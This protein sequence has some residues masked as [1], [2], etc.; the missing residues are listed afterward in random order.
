[1]PGTSL[2]AKVL[3]KSGKLSGGNF[4]LGFDLV[5]G[6]GVLVP[7]SLQGRD[8][9]LAVGGDVGVQVGDYV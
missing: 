1:V 7:P 9:L 8:D 5:E 2:I 4:P 6:D 3:Q